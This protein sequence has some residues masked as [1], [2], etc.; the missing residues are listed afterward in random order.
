MKGDGLRDQERSITC[1]RTSSAEQVGVSKAKD[2]FCHYFLDLN[3][4]FGVGNEMSMFS[5]I[6]MCT[7]TRLSALFLVSSLKKKKHRLQ[8]KSFQ[9]KFAHKTAQS[10]LILIFIIFMSLKWA[11][12]V[13]SSPSSNN[14]QKMTI[15]F[16]F[17]VHV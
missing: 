6:F 8:N 14:P 17:C 13:S 4:V 9:I 1:E 11:L 10:L 12:S 3:S 16:T 2:L 7:G 15:H 5:V